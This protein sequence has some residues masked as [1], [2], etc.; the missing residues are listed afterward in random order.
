MYHLQCARKWWQVSHLGFFLSLL[1]LLVSAYLWN[2]SYFCTGVALAIL[3]IKQLNSHGYMWPQWWHGWTV[4]ELTRVVKFVI[5]REK[6][7]RSLVFLWA[8]S[9]PE[10]TQWILTV[11]R[12]A[13]A[14]SSCWICSSLTPLTRWSL[15]ASLGNAPNYQSTSSF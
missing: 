7:T 9:S 4:L 3:K 12:S 13:S 15:S 5:E 14:K 2:K 1:I 6:K 11:V 8:A 10:L